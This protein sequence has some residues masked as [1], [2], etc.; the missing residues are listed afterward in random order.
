[1]NQYIIIYFFFIFCFGGCKRDVEIVQK[2]NKEKRV[3]VTTQD[4][5]GT[6]EDHSGCGEVLDLRGIEFG[7]TSNVKIYK[8]NF[9]NADTINWSKPFAK[10]TFTI[11]DS[12]TVSFMLIYDTNSVAII[13]TNYSSHHVFLSTIFNF[14]NSTNYLN[15]SNNYLSV[16]FISCTLD[17]D[18]RYC[19]PFGCS[20][21]TFYKIK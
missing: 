2:S 1:M 11:T 4:L 12:N 18:N 7:S 5:V 20:I 16:E 10:G 8:N 21:K 6:W 19:D 15:D 9:I 13:D 3:I 14:G 17:K